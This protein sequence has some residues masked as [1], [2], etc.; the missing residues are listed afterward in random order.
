MTP[1]NN[2]QW[3]SASNAFDMYE[4]LR[5]RYCNN[6]TMVERCNVMMEIFADKMTAIEMGK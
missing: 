3:I 5:E 6:P 4:G 2:P 1:Q